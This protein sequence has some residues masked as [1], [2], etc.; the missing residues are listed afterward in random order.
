MSTNNVTVPKVVQNS[1]SRPV[2]N[3][4]S[5]TTLKEIQTGVLSDLKNAII[6]SMGPAGSNSLI[7][8]GNSDADIVAEYSKDGNKII[9]SIKYQYP[10]EMAIKS[11]IEN[12]TRHIEKEV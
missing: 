1:S 4:V 3:I 7:L 2:N 6:H 12:A 8:R 11:E 9:K 10:I 5:G